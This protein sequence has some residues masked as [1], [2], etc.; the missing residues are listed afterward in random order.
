MS[1]KFG[2]YI[3][4]FDGEKFYDFPKIEALAAADAD[5]LAE[6]KLGYRTGYIL[7]TARIFASSGSG[8]LICD[9]LSKISGA[10][11]QEAYEL[12]ISLPGI[13]PKVANCILLFSLGR[14]EVFPIDVWVKK[15]M[16]SLYGFAE[17]DL[18][19]M[20]K[21]AARHF[22]AYG[23]VAQQYLFFYMREKSGN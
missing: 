1:E 19:G 17:N 12:L 8:D 6:I 7:D 10:D 22:G 20:K 9:M 23:G 18:A 13:G 11:T 16:C 3:G 2:E 4:T 14:K 5:S 21:Y 15:T